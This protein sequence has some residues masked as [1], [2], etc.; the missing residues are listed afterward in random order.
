MYSTQF[1][2]L[3]Y[4]IM[5]TVHNSMD[6]RTYSTQCAECHAIP[7]VELHST[8]GITHLEFH[9][10]AWNWYAWSSIPNYTLHFQLQNFVEWNWSSYSI[11]CVAFLSLYTVH[12]YIHCTYI[13][14]SKH[15]T[16][17]SSC[18]RFSL[19]I[20]PSRCLQNFCVLLKYLMMKAWLCLMGRSKS[21][22]Y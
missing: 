20:S 15:T 3:T 17:V 2:G 9:F 11:E 8:P 1:H 16:F 14:T 10:H 21:S 18:P 19:F 4:K 6:V 12:T 22:T 7:G 5:C 13:H